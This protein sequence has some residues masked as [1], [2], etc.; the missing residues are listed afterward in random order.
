[1]TQTPSPL[2]TGFVPQT[3]EMTQSRAQAKWMTAHCAA[4]LAAFVCCALAIGLSGCAIKR[5]QRIPWAI[6]IQARPNSPA[7]NLEAGADSDSALPIL[8]MELPSFPGTLVF[9]RMSPPRPHVISPSTGAGT[10]GVEPEKTGSPSFTPQL[11]AQESNA[12][13]HEMQDSLTIAEKNLAIAGNRKLNPAQ[14]DLLSK[15]RSYIKDA[16]E[17]AQG[18][19]WGHARSSAKKAQV[20]SEELVGSL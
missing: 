11:S 13:R 17:A 10:G 19:D 15:I 18:N 3:K 20:L 9:P 14:A 5:R 8:A 4:R 12:A 6:A 16:R 7:H 2:A 1:M